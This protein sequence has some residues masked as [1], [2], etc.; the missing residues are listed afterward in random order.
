MNLSKFK[1]AVE[2][3]RRFYRC[4]NRWLGKGID[5]W[6]QDFAAD[7]VRVA[8]M[9]GLF[10]LF[11]WIISGPSA[12]PAVVSATTPDTVAAPTPVNDE[13]TRLQLSFVCSGPHAKLVIFLL[14]SVFVLC[15]NMARRLRFSFHK[16][17]VEVDKAEAKGEDAKAANPA[18]AVKPVQEVANKPETETE[19]NF[20][21][22]SSKENSK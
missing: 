3:L 12:A 16:D 21:T 13:T 6:L 2:P 18:P 17:F 14:Y 11:V 15:F 7:C 10:Y 20:S 9:L 4:I 8:F 1:L 19:P 22:Q 5:P